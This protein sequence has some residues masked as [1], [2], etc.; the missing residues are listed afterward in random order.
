MNEETREKYTIEMKGI[1]KRFSGIAALSGVDFFLRAGEVN[2]L[3]GENGAG[4]STL[5][6]ILSG[7]HKAD[8]GTI[9]LDGK[10]VEIQNPITAR[11]LGIV[12]IYQE[13]D[14]IDCLS[15]AENIFLCN[16]PM[17]NR[18]QID[19]AEMSR[20]ADELLRGLNMDFDVRRKVGNLSVAHK[21]MVAIAKALSVESRV[22]ILDEPSD[23]LTGRELESL[24]ETIRLIRDKGVAIVYISHRLEEIFEIGDLVTV[25]RDGKLVAVKPVSEIDK[26]KLISLMVGRYV[27]SDTKRKREDRTKLIVLEAKNIRRG[28]VLR[29]ISF[30]LREGEI[31]GLSGLVGAGRSEL[32]RAIVGAD[33][34]DSGELFIKGKKLKIKGPSEA[35]EAGIGLVPEERKKDGL[36]L[37]QSV[38]N[39]T[40]LS[41]LKRVSRFGLMS[42]KR[43][44]ETVD[45]YVRDFD[46]KISGHNQMVKN[47]SGGNQQKIV[48]SKWLATG[49][50]IL[51]LDEPTR[52]ID[53][54][55]KAEIHKIIEDFAKSGH[56]VLLISS[57][58]PELLALSDRIIVLS[59]GKITKSFDDNNVSQEEILTYAM[60]RS[61]ME[62]GGAA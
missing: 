62:E 56:S 39:N 44:A 1:T 36:V 10:P 32:A 12:P 6:K 3:L 16:E 34:I 8:E 55:A 60:P 21:Q 54:S 59:E 51:I 15:I 4:K 43:V 17:K 30:Y 7:A 40:V 31:L 58:M 46:T 27:S 5:I 61:F 28:N 23:V 50:E 18:F 19:H 48:L 35:A 25:L 57:E 20:R 24:F 11:K 52:G 2:C 42:V 29:D 14:L 13:L 49:V 47:L 22:F 53:V 37:I 26:P 9:S 45:R 38:A 41:I 33:P